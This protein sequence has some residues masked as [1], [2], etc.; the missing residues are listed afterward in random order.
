MS[1]YPKRKENQ[2]DEEYR[3][4]V[5]EWIKKQFEKDR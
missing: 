3:Q 4:E 5:I 2:I 1:E